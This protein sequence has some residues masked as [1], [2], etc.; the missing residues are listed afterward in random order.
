[1]LDGASGYVSVSEQAKSAIIG[2]SGSF[3]FHLQNGFR[4]AYEGLSEEVEL[5]TLDLGGVEYMDSSGLGMLLVMKKYLDEVKVN[6][7]ITNSR[8]QTLDLLKMTHF[9]HFFKINGEE[10]IT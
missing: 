2:I 4:K 9:N 7:E 6:Y 8:D 3:A 1:M 5:L 10:P